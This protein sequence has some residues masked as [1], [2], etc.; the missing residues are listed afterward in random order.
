MMSSSI[1]IVRVEKDGYTKA[2]YDSVDLRFMDYGPW[3]NETVRT[4]AVH[5]KVLVINI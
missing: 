3:G 4:F 2:E 5:G 1:D